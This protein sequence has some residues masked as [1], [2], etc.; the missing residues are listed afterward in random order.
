LILGHPAKKI[1]TFFDPASSK[2]S[3]RF[4]EII[5]QG[6]IHAG[7]LTRKLST[8]KDSYGMVRGLTWDARTEE[9]TILGDC[10]T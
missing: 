10:R 7:A 1:V 5:T 4:T 8:R 2:A 6:A 3:F 9:S